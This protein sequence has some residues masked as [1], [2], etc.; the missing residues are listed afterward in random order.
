M[1]TQ[2]L[3]GVPAVVEHGERPFRLRCD[4][5]AS[6]F[7]SEPIPG[8]QSP[9]YAGDRYIADAELARRERARQVTP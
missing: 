5:E 7:T 3:R 2:I 8:I 4:P 9:F 6:S 1:K